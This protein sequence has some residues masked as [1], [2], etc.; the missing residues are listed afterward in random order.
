M[1]FNSKKY[2]IDADSSV[3]KALEKMEKNHQGIILVCSSSEE[4]IG[5]AT[6]GD[7]RRA[8]LSGVTVDDSISLCANRDFVWESIHSPRENLIKKL[9]SHI[10]FIP[11]LD[12][13]KKLKMLV[14]KDFLPLR[15]E[16]ETF[17]RAR[18]PVRVSFGG[19]GSDVTNYF[20]GNTGA[21]INSTISLYSHATMKIVEDSSIEIHSLDLGE[22]LYASSLEEAMSNSGSFGLIL[23][24]LKVINPQYGFRLYLHSDFPIGSGL[25][26]SAT[27]AAAILGCF[28]MLRHDRWNR[29]EL[30]EIAYQAERL[31]LGV[32]G[33][34]QDQYATVF[35]GFNFLEFDK[36]ENIINPIR[37]H[38]EILFEL[39]ESLVLCDTGISHDSGNIHKDQKIASDL[40]SIKKKVKEN[41]ELTYE[42]KNHLLRGN[43]GNFGS[44]LHRA[45]QIKKSLSK[46]ITNAEINKIYEGAIKNGALGGKLL[47]AGGGGF[48]IFYVPPFQK[49]NL[50]KYLEKINLNVQPF[51][52]EPE[53]LK[54]WTSRFSNISELFKDL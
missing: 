18:A 29:H 52:F 33:G 20:S 21:V 39:E 51:R 45:W 28:N 38:D 53:G 50:I 1:K 48:F 5:L 3:K 2:L 14:S 36:K 22:T 12:D 8:L 40:K 37:I 44:S 11:I 32:A 25:G 19:G 10:K 23:S 42:I 7:I 35:G 49:H 34:W 46:K 31:H 54:T 43:L 16:E 47:G 41:V 13:A 30:A 6:D 24:T 9:E 27:L 17:I 4:I 15:E 26:G